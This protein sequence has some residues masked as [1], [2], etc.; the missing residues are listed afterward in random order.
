MGHE[1]FMGT[2][3]GISTQGA[4]GQGLETNTWNSQCE[5]EMTTHFFPRLERFLERPWVEKRKILWQKVRQEWHALPTLRR[6]EPGFLFVVWGD[7]AVRDAV[8]SGE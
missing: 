5:G 7:D 2:A 8:L 3:L 4:G 6:L 1:V